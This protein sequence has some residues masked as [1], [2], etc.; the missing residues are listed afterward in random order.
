MILSNARLVLS[1]RIQFGSLRVN[2][3]R[4]AA[5]TGELSPAPGEE[6]VDLGGQF[7]APGFIDLHIHGALRRDTMEATSEAFTEIC[8]F[9]AG[10]GTTSL[11]LTTV[12]ASNDEILRVLEAVKAYR[13]APGPGAQVLGVHLEGPYFSKEKPGAHD[14]TLIRAP[15]RGEW[16]RWL[17]H[18]DVITQLTLAPELPGAL[19]LIDALVAAGVR[20]SAGHSDAWDDDCAAAFAHGLRQATHTFNCMSS[21]RRRGPYRVAG[22]LEFALSEP[23]MLCE[24]IADGRHVSP[25]LMRVLARAKGPDSIALITDASAGAG[26]AEGEPFRLLGVDC[27]VHDE[28]G[29]TVDG[30]A[31]AGSTATMIR[32]VR[33]MVQLVDASLPEAVR[34]ATLNPARALGIEGRKGVLAPGAAAD[35]VV[36][37]DDFQVS[38]TFVA[39]RDVL[40]PSVAF[41]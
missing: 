37:D 3:G 27:R 10:G 39:G 35:L 26:L 1:D 41:S 9:H 22:L 32:C 28:V 40:E 19:S 29:L 12:T 13:L 16:S 5:L 7:L 23:E 36:F 21:T 30:K 34:M 38:H 18:A 17:E 6:V 8:R 15:D 14:L 33:N 31:L 20:P 25:T 11:A 2:E 24:L 4:I